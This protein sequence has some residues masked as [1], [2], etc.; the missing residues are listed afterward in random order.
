[1]ENMEKNIKQKKSKF[2]FLNPAATGF[3]LMELMVVLFIFVALTSFMVINLNSK[4]SSRDIKLAQS[5]FVSNIRKVQ[6]YTLESRILPSGQS[7]QY[8]ILKI[9]FQNPTQYQIQA[10]TNASSNPKLE[11]LETIKLPANIQ[12]ATP[13]PVSI[14]ER[15]ATP[16]TQDLTGMS[17]IL[18]AF[19]APFGKVFF[20]D[21]CNITNPTTGIIDITNS[22]DDYGK[23]LNFQSN[24][25]CAG[26]R[27]PAL[28]TLSTDSILAVSLTDRFK[29]V[30]KTVTV[31][32]ASGTITFN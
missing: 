1:M 15:L 10:I 27:N 2:C 16:S 11:T 19:S 5:Q 28:C 9:D 25:A 24:V 6:S 22:S 29:T 3:T 13:S 14:T 7:V 32:S 30:S 23:I 21:G 18:V 17:C 20:N 4:R 8:Y 31:K 26:L 12:F